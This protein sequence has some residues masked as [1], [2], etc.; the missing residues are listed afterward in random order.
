MTGAI[1]VLG[2][3]SCQ[4]AVV[5]DIQ[6]SHIAANVPSRADFGRLLTQALG[7]YFNPDRRPY[8]GIGHQLLREEPTQS[9]V[10]YPKFYVWVR[11]FNKGLVERQGA[12]RLEAIERRE[13]RITDFVVFDAKK[14]KVAKQC[15]DCNLKKAE[16][17]AWKYFQTT[18]VT[19]TPTP[20]PEETPGA[21]Q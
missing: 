16:T 11:V 14:Q 4:D 21:S 5:E 18:Q 3:L 10:A 13:F 17:T 2:L 8:V 19:P 6:S 20:V 15:L 1:L 12:V 7:R 9:G